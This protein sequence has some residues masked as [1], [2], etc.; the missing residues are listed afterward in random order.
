MEKVIKVKGMMCPH[1][2]ARV[3]SA[4][5]SV[6]GVVS[7]VASHKDGTVTVVLKGELE[8]GILEGVI[9]EQGYKVV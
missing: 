4:V 7:A 1:C 6:E 5:E 8:D 2:E 3:K 9:T